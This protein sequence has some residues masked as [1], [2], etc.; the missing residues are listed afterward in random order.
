MLSLHPLVHALQ[1]RLLLKECAPTSFQGRVRQSDSDRCQE[2]FAA[3][4]VLTW[5]AK[6][7]DNGAIGTE[8]ENPPALFLMHNRLDVR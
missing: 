1:P 8:C 2:L 6:N 5:L 4:D 3:H 7:L